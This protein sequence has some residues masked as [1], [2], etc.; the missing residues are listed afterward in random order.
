MINR[1]LAGAVVVLAGLVLLSRSRGVEEPPVAASPDPTSRGEVIQGAPPVRRRARVE[2]YPID[3]VAAA[4]T[5]AIDLRAR[6]AVRRRIDREGTNVY[7][8][9]LLAHTDSAII[10]WSDQKRV[11]LR[12]RIEP[13][14]TLPQ[15]S[16]NMLNAVRAGMAAWRGNQAGIQLVETTD[17]LAADITVRFSLTLGTSEFGATDLSWGSS[18]EVTTATIR[19]AIKPEPTAPNPLPVPVVT[20]VAAHE[21]GHA[22]GLPH[23]GDRRDLMFF[24]TPGD[25]P[26]RRDLAT[27]MLLY[28]VPP[29]SLK[30][31]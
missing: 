25:T 7:L 3:P 5:P 12:V 14:S 28:A 27:L 23:S 9:S 15:W 8:D 30:E 13:D 22:L 11:A 20:R 21:F 19:I 2:L 31:P 29:G 17:S 26:T 18:G 1:W 16:P 10:R 6:L 4:A 24:T